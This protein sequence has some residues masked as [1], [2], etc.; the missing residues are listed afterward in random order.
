[1]L[2]LKKRYDGF[3]CG[4]RRDS[5][6]FHVKGRIRGRASPKESILGV[7]HV[8]LICE[9]LERSME[10]Y[11]GMLGLN[12]NPGRPNAKLP[13]R[14]AY[15]I[16]GPGQ[17]VH[18][19]E[20]PNPDPVDLSQRPEHGGRDRHLCVSVSDLDIVRSVL[21]ENNWPYTVSRSG[22]PALFTRDPDANTLEFAM[23]IQEGTSTG[24]E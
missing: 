11:C 19:M 14:G 5:F 12:T 2:R 17:E 1:M 24:Q 8:A 13:F 4:T 21:E 22:R 18:L 16:I 9:N 15:V 7:Q 6:P 3:S 20:L 10:F 23:V